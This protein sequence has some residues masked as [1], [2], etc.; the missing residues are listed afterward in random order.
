MTAAEYLTNLRAACLIPALP[1]WSFWVEYL[2]RDV[3]V[4]A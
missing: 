4:E 2:F 1:A 3:E